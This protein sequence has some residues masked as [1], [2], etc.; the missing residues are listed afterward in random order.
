MKKV[1]F[2]RVKFINW[3]FSVILL[4]LKIYILVILYK[5]SMFIYIY[6]FI[7]ECIGVYIYV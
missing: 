2:V 1:V 7:Q 3:L 4:I 6:L 5:L